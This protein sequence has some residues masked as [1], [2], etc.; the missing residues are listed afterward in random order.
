MPFIE[1]DRFPIYFEEHGDPGAPLLLMIM[2][3][4]FSSRAWE[5]LPKQLS[6]THR[7]ITFDNRWTGRS[8]P[9]PK[10]SALSAID[11]ARSRVFTMRELADDAAAILKT[12]DAPAFVFGV[13]MGGMIAQELALQHGE[14]VRALALG[15]TFADYALREPPKLG[16]LIDLVL[17]STMPGPRQRDRMG[18][19]LVSDAF[20][21]TSADR[22][23]RWLKNAE[24]G[25]R[26]LAL[27]QMSAVRRHRT[28]DRLAALRIPTLVLTGD[29]DR[30]VPPSGSR[31]IAEL[32]PGARLELLRGAGHVFPL[33]REDDTAA[34]LLSHFK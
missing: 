31:Q 25:G 10:D 29:E 9:D 27:A 34:L 3:M 1:R 24:F 2:G 32:I 20:M 8:R 16:V 30:L 17:A 23:G 26:R 7:V 11:I 22:F 14:R 28:T 19:H 5:A 13:S 33:E 21:K 6:K 15:A 4:G 18:K 12:L